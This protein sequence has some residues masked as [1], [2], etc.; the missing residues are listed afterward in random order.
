MLHFFVH[1]VW[2]MCIF[3]GIPFHDVPCSHYLCSKTSSVIYYA[4]RLICMLC[5][6]FLVHHYICTCYIINA[7]N[8]LFKGCQSAGMGQWQHADL[9]NQRSWVRIWVPPKFKGVFYHKGGVLS[10]NIKINTTPT[11]QLTQFSNVI[12]KLCKLNC[13]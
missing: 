5:E 10:L 9:V 4:V 11:I 6:Y 3:R 13:L 8:L 2:Y 7:S 12:D 1:R